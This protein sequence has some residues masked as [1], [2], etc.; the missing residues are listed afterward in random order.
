MTPL[1][2]V[3]GGPFG[4]ILADP[5]WSFRTWSGKKG[6]PHRSANDHYM[7]TATADLA[8]LPVQEL[9]AKDCAL[10]MWVVDSHIDQAIELGR[11]WGFRFKTRAF[12]WR[13]LTAKGTPRIGM[14]YWT[15][16]QTELCLLFTR[17]KVRRK[18]KGVR[19]IIDA[20][21]REHSRK[22]DEQYERIER[23]VDG[24][25]IELFARQRRAGWQAWGNEVGRFEAANDNHSP[26][27]SRSRAAL[28]R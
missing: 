4:C 19:E 24:P 7:T 25:Y 21:R 15:R 5:P 2:D 14:G 18:D 13:K 17:G 20:P 10:F 27:T 3:P 26:A 9:A 28:A 12:T 16:K 11:A 6:T 1:D 22:P 23:L 8:A